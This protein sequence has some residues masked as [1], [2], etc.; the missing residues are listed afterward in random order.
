MPA[1]AHLLN[2]KAS[3]A[4]AKPPAAAATIMP[5]RAKSMRA[6]TH[7]LV[8]SWHRRTGLTLGLVLVFMAA[9]GILLP[10]RSRME[11]G[12]EPHLLTAPA[13]R[14]RVPLHTLAS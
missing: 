3:E 11:P 5:A 7:R 9:T 13:C 12:G 8:L 10:Y 14:T 1:S 4:V 2:G 6:V